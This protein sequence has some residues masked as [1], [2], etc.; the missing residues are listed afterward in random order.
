MKDDA[1]IVAETHTV[2][3]NPTG[4]TLYTVNTTKSMISSASCTRKGLNSK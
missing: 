2:H 4:V 3:V 1:F